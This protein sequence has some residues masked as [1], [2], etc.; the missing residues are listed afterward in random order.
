MDKIILKSYETDYFP[1]LEGNLHLIMWEVDKKTVKHTMFYNSVWLTSHVSS[2]DFIIET[3]NLKKTRALQTLKNSVLVAQDDLLFHCPNYKQMTAT[4]SNWKGLRINHLFFACLWTH[5]KMCWQVL[6]SHLVNWK[7]IRDQRKKGIHWTHLNASRQCH[8][9]WLTGKN[10]GKRWKLHG[11]LRCKKAAKPRLSI[12][13]YCKS[14][15]SWMNSLQN[16]CVHPKWTEWTEE[17]G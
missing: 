10:K 11:Y 16:Y 3:E 4:K 5:P 6:H 14:P 13:N 17:T 8:V 15:L 1:K 12:E 7:W 9:T 2:P